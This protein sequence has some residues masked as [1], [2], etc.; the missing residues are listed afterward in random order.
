[1]ADFSY[2]WAKNTRYYHQ[3]VR[4]VDSP[5]T[6]AGPKKTT[7]PLRTTTSLPHAGVGNRIRAA[8]IAR[9]DPCINYDRMP[10]QFIVF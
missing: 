3:Y 10:I 9:E 4:Y 2:N 7:N 1:M 6:F 5:N 8:A